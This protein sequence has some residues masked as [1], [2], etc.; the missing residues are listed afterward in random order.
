MSSVYS[1]L[2]DLGDQSLD[3]NLQKMFLIDGQRLVLLGEWGAGA[4]VG[5]TSIDGLPSFEMPPGA[6]EM[7]RRDVN[8]ANGLLAMAPRDLYD[9]FVQARGELLDAVRGREA[10]AGKA[11]SPLAISD[12]LAKNIERSFMT[13]SDLA[14]RVAAIRSRVEEAVAAARTTFPSTA[15]SE[16]QSVLYDSAICARLL[17][18][19]PGVFASLKEGEMPPTLDPRA[20]QA[21][22]RVPRAVTG[23]TE[24][25]LRVIVDGYARSAAPLT[26]KA[27]EVLGGLVEQTRMLICS[28][29]L[30]LAGIALITPDEAFAKLQDGP[31]IAGAMRVVG[32]TGADFAR[33]AQ[34][35][36]TAE[37]ARRSQAPRERFRTWKPPI[38]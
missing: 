33:A 22:A 10:L 5:T 29:V 30:N 18:I 24:S 35:V 38:G 21:L 19:D 31:W 13:L 23:L 28:A 4:P 37:A 8:R 3:V 11:Y 27:V 14:H 32:L 16:A 15:E 1:T 36:A 9:I 12:A 7:Q 6:D 2:G 17:P 25:E 20:I 34:A 26:A